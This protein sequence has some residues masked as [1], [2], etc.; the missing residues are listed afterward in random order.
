MKKIIVVSFFILSGFI[1]SGLAQKSE[2]QFV[3]GSKCSIEIPEGFENKGAFAGVQNKAKSTNMLISFV[4]SSATEFENSFQP[5]SMKAKGFEIKEKTTEKVAQGSATF[6]KTLNTKNQVYKLVLF[7]EPEPKTLICITGEFP[8]KNKEIEATV[9]SSMLSI[10]YDKEHK[11]DLTAFAP[12]KL[13]VP[14]QVMKPTKGTPGTLVYSS[15]GTSSIISPENATL[16]I[17][18]S[19]LTRPVAELKQYCEERSIKNYRIKDLKV[20]ETKAVKYD[21]L[22]GYECVTQGTQDGKPILVYYTYLF[23]DKR[24]FLINGTAMGDL[25][26]QLKQFREIA[27]TFKRK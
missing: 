21:G 25:S 11:D 14:E 20:T 18:L 13:N 15:S 24:I 26:S 7:F 9:K 5:D 1:Q 8:E 12:F 23:Q 10:I 6:L 22:E 3:T 2:R 27:K 19:S 17:T 4:K 16:L